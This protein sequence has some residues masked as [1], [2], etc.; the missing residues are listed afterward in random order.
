MYTCIFSYTYRQYLLS[1]LCVPTYIRI[2]NN[3]ISIRLLNKIHRRQR[4]VFIVDL[5]LH[6][7]RENY[8]NRKVIYSIFIAANIRLNG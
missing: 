5:L 4:L 7:S 6:D 8:H 1:F 3:S 2:I